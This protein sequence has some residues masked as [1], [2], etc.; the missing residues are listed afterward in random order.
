MYLKR[1][2][3]V[4]QKKLLAYLIQEELQGE[5]QILQGIDK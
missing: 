2:R 3:K 5:K 4:T 1:Y